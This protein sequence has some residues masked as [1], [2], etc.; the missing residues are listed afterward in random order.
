MIDSEAKIRWMRSIL[1]FMLGDGLFWVAFFWKLSYLI[2]V[3]KIH[4][5]IAGYIYLRFM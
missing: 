1:S 3:D 2:R 4:S 5:V